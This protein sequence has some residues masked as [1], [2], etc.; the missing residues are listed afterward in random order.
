MITMYVLSVAFNLFFWYCFVSRPT[1]AF[2]VSLSEMGYKKW[3]M[4]LASFIP[5][6]STLLAIIL[7]IHSYVNVV[8]IARRIK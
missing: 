1:S 3:P 8:E 6:V 7:S 5:L 2:S 4:L